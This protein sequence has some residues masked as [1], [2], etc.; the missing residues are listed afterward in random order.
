MDGVLDAPTAH[1]RNAR[2][3]HGDPICPSCDAVIA[4]TQSVRDGFRVHLVCAV[5]YDT[6]HR[7]SLD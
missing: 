4:S 2:S 7:H 6:A 1:L 3:P 5:D